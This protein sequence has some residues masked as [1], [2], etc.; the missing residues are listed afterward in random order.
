MPT[1]SEI[2]RLSCRC[3]EYKSQSTDLQKGH[4][5]LFN[6]F[7]RTPRCD[8]EIQAPRLAGNSISVTIG[9]PPLPRGYA[10][11][12]ECL[13]GHRLTGMPAGD[14]FSVTLIA[15]SSWTF[16]VQV[17]MAPL[18]LA[19]L[20][21]PGLAR[22]RLATWEL[23]LSPST[24]PSLPLSRHTLRPL[25][26]LPTVHLLVPKQIIPPPCNWQRHS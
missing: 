23:R 5:F 26:L 1:R 17:Y 25:C 10:R 7:P 11:M 19:A 4:L 12:L 22:A 24:Y 8:S 6:L 21:P 9:Q 3:A 18:D 13:H 16:G 15:G 20:L 14:P 2:Q